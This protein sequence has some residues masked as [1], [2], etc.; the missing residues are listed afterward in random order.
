MAEKYIKAFSK[1]LYNRIEDDT[2]PDGSAHD[3][4]NWVTMGDR[5]ELRR[6][7]TLLGT[8]VSGNGNISGLFVAERFDG[9]QV[10]FQSYDRKIRYYDTV[11]EDWIET[12]TADILPASASGEDVAFAQYHSLAGAFLYASSKNS[13]IYKIPIANPASIVDLLSTSI[14]GKI[15][16]KQGRMFLWDKKDASSGFDP[17]GI[18]GSYIDKDEQV[19]YTEI[20][21]E[22]IGSSGSTNYTGTL[23]F[24][25][26]FPKRTCMYVTFSATTVSGTELFI[27]TR[28]GTLLS[29]FG[30]TGTIDYATGAY[31]ITFA[32][33]TTGA[34]TSG[35]RWEDSTST[36]IADFSKSTPRTAGQGFTFRQDDG[37]AE[38][39][40]IFTFGSDEYCLHTLK[41]WKLTLQRDDTEATNLIYR[42]NVGIPYWRAGCE[43]G[44]GIYFADAPDSSDPYIRVLQ[45][46]QLGTDIIPSS[47]SDRLD[48]RDYRFNTC[49][50]KEWGNYIA[51]ACRHKDATENDTL[52]LY[53]KLFKLW[54]RFDYRISCMDVYNGALVAGDSASKNVFTLFSDL[55]DEDV[56]IPNYWISN[57]T[58]F[59]VEGTVES[60]LFQ[61]NGLIQDDQTVE[62]LFSY[63]NG[64]FVKVGEIVGTGSYVDRT[65]RVTV[66]SLVMGAN[67]IGGGSSG[68]EASPYNREFRVVT[69]RFQKIQVKFQATRV[70]YVSIS[71]YGFKDVRR[72][73]RGLPPQYQVN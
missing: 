8:D 23:A 66:G 6:G 14:R 27:D 71:Q 65:Q 51:V 18:Y 70:G 40:N 41:T 38:T 59:N 5:I 16:I 44:D 28:N 17:N 22:A 52:F 46:N 32:S 21:G 53:N 33:A 61:I 7:Q 50:V 43:T 55:T 37:G 35:Y 60:N 26:G 47:I 56:E 72:K 1:G 30:G 12:T 63:D 15:K 20:I 3:S 62:V 42:S 11:S 34:V 24:K 36:G 69:P 49:V 9:T 45:P 39:Q 57:K 67:E 19:D 25:A 29:N 73:G 31:N 48:L 54:D 13:G 58:N 68:I 2:I 4:L 10:L 64:D